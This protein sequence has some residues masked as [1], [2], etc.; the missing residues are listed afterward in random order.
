MPEEPR[1]LAASERGTITYY[2]QRNTLEL[3]WG[4]A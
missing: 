1:E 4:A 2:P 3:A